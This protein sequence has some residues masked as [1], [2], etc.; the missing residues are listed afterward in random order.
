M[1]D[2]IIVKAVAGTCIGCSFILVGN[3]ITQTFMTVPALIV[4]FPRPGTPEHSSRARLLGRQWPLCW[5]V[6]NT[7]FRPIS[8]FGVLGYSFAS[9]SLYKEGILA[10]ANWRWFAVAAALHLTTVV[11]SAVNM[12]PLNDKLESLASKTSEK[13]LREAEGIA[14]KW[15]S[16]NR[17]RMVTPV[18]AGILALWQIVQ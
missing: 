4:D 3:A 15:G 2:N 16:W 18:L 8:T 5:S 14:R 11:H 6:G 9:Y 10:R 12:Q 13:D 17:V 7:F 1:T